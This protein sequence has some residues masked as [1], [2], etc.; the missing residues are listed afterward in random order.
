M[1]NWQVGSFM[2][3]VCWG[4]RK[5]SDKVLCPWGRIN[6]IF[7]LAPSRLTCCY[8]DRTTEVLKADSQFIFLAVLN[9]WGEKSSKGVSSCHTPVIFI[10][11]LKTWGPIFKPDLAWPNQ[12]SGSEHS[13][14]DEGVSSGL[15]SFQSWKQCLPKLLHAD[16]RGLCMWSVL[17][18]SGSFLNKKVYASVLWICT[19]W[20]E[21]LRN[22]LWWCLWWQ[23][24]GG[25]RQGEH[26]ERTEG[27]E[28]K[29]E[30]AMRGH[31]LTQLPLSLTEPHGDF[32]SSAISAKAHLYALHPV[33]LQNPWVVSV[34]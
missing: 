20:N 10:V 2:Q 6:W 5:I 12:P 17:S 30:T 4:W 7:S 18:L 1:K 32:T 22:F 24:K 8:Y 15:P 11:C 25:G 28:L 26:K 23:W 21:P 27:V 9:Y 29:Q 13:A 3:N 34:G 33:C 14:E 16:A 19:L 31:N